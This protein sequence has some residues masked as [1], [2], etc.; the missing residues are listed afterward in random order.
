MLI[1]E[2]LLDLNS[3]Q[4]NITAA[5]VRAN[6]KEGEEVCVSVPR[7]FTKKW[8]VLKLKKTLY[9]LR[10]FPWAFWKY[11]VEKMKLSDMP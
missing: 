3:K 1:S 8:K 2:A 7:G 9:G 4:G 10:Q 6:L 5:F 11:L